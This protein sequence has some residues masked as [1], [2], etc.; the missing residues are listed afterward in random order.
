M[1]T[2]VAVT[3]AA[4]AASPVHAASEAEK[5]RE[6]I[7]KS[8]TLYTLA[9]FLEA[10]D[11]EDYKLVDLFLKAGMEVNS[12]NEHGQTALLE[13]ADG[14]DAKMIGVL[15]KAGADVNGRDNDG[16]TPLWKAV[17]SG[18]TDRGIQGTTALLAAR[19]DLTLRYRYGASIVHEAV[20]SDR[21]EALSALLKAGAEVDARND[22]GETAL[23]ESACTGRVKVAPI[24]IAAGADVNAKTKDQATPLQ[25]AALCGE[26]GI[27]RLLL[28]AGADVKAADKSG[29]TALQQVAR[30]NMH[31]VETGRIPEA[32]LTQIVEGLIAKGADVNSADAYQG[33]TPLMDA[34]E[35]GNLPVVRALL[36]AGAEVNR[37]SGDGSTALMH[38]AEKGHAD[39]VAALIEAK[40]DVNV[41]N[42]MGK[43]ALS[44][45]AASPE[46]AALLKAAGA[47]PATRKK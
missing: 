32:N 37:K 35:Q 24:L 30:F 26:A 25:S 1:K 11:D 33:E 6:K 46:V 16:E 20:S 28:D 47:G 13:A 9:N 41:R 5:A 36:T 39:V 18:R 21:P 17:G 29:V 19:P 2:I 10:V 14:N 44:L 22:D 4:L 43:T 34:A 12:R 7:V 45:A 3:V 27:V 23:Y 40:A 42:R 8:G 31:F 15:L 38:A